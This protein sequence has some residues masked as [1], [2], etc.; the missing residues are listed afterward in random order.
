MKSL[1]LS[2]FRKSAT[3]P[4]MPQSQREETPLASPS[5][6]EE[7]SHEKACKALLDKDFY[8]TH[9]PDIAASGA[10]A[11]THYIDVGSKEGRIP[12]TIDTPDAAGAIK[13]ALEHDPLN[14]MAI[15]LCIALDAESKEVDRVSGALDRYEKSFADA[16]PDAELRSLFERTAIYIFAR[17]YQF[18]GTDEIADIVDLLTRMAAVFTESAIID[19]VRALCIF[20][21]GDLRRA[22]D[23]LIALQDLDAAPP[24]LKEQCVDALNQIADAKVINSTPSSTPQLLIF[25]TWFPSGFSSFR[26]GEFSTYLSNIESSAIHIRPD[27]HRLRLGETQPLPDQIAEFATA[28]GVMMNRLRRFDSTQ[29]GRAKVA[30]C[31]FLNLADRFFSQ[32]APNSADHFIFTLY[33][34]GGFAPND[35]RSDSVLR[36][37]CENPRVSKI[38]TTQTVSY[39]YLVDGGFCEPNRIEH[40]Y[41]VVIP[42]LFTNRAPAYQ[43]REPA[44]ALD[45]CFVAQRYS[46]TGAEKGY[47]VFA[48]VV[49]RFANSPLINFHVVGGFDESIIDLRGARNIKFYGTRPASFFHDF[50]SEMDVILS[51]NIQMSKLD[52]SRPDIFDGFPT[53]T[54]MEAGLRGA[55]MVL[56]DFQN[57]N[58]RL[59]GSKL[60]SDDE[61]V[62]IDRN[63]DQIVSILNSFIEDRD[64][65]E[66][67]GRSGQKAIL[68]ELSYERQMQPRLDLLNSY[69]R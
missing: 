7:T 37:L 52:P 15:R 39:R 1:L 54:V 51:P 3:S 56:T 18:T 42:S 53:T 14:K 33:P 50:Y 9:Y 46:A 59:D 23:A 40:I 34:G 69:L 20:E 55:V 31:V 26:Y 48:E 67:L 60:F 57:M 21:T 28:S 38:I 2:L 65:V 43:R 27:Q 36:R 35:P 68:R 66:K 30:Y 13:K 16:E 63:P 5:A 10:D 61:M 12:R 6:I 29:T 22:E 62:I 64:L 58:R 47:D 24:Y 32:L 4:G 25:D 17:Y 49:A 41:G 11:L 44:K 19:S 8:L 45:V